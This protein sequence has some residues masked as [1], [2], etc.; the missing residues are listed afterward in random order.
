MPVVYFTLPSIA[1]MQVTHQQNRKIPSS[2]LAQLITQVRSCLDG[3][4]PLREVGELLLALLG[5][6][7]PL[8]LGEAAADSAG[9]LG[10][11][12]EGSVLLVLVEQAELLALCGVDDGEDTGDGLAD[13]V[14][15][16]NVN[17]GVHVLSR[18]SVG[19]AAGNCRVRTSW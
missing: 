4:L 7:F 10:S 6:N 3:E 12:V 13:V 5:D 16:Y 17:I 15:V 14:A 9:L 19:F 18:F 2:S 1:S 11:E 8:V